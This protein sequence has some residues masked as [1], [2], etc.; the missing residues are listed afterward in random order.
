LSSASFGA[1]KERASHRFSALQSIQLAFDM[2]GELL[3]PYKYADG[4]GFFSA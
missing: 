2:S 1:L 3:Y 4:I